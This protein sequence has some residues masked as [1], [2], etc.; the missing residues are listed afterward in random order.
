MDRITIDVVNSNGE[1]SAFHKDRFA[2]YLIRLEHPRD[3]AI[4]LADELERELYLTPTRMITTAD[5]RRI[6][7]DL[8][9]TG[10]GRLAIERL[11]SELRTP[12]RGP[13]ADNRYSFE[14]KTA[15]AEPRRVAGGNYPAVKPDLEARLNEGE[16][17]KP[18]YVP[19]G[20]ER[21]RHVH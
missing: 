8:T 1:H 5:L 11:L 21:G 9:V 14:L 19:R 15:K 3:A 6:A 12:T 13:S 20:P 2:G 17:D 10:T 4:E 16:D 7:A 18:Y